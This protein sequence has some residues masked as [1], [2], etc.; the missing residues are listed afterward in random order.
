MAMRRPARVGYASPPMSAADTYD[1]SIAESYDAEY[2]VLRDPSGDQAFYA[3]LARASGGPVLELGCGTGRVILPIAREGIPCVGLD[4]SPTMLDVLRAK[5]PPGN[6]ELVQAPMTDFDLGAA[7]FRLIF[8]AFRPLQ[9]LCTVEEQL[10]T[11]ACVRRHL[12]PG[13]RFAFDLFAPNLARTAIEE[14]PEQEDVRAPDGDGEIRRFA[15]VRRDLAT[16]VLT[17]V[18]RHERWVG[19]AKVSEGTSELRMRWFHRYEVEHLL[20]RAGF[21]VEALYG[22]FD[23]RPFDAKGEMIFVTRAAP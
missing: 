11:L 6:L 22:K 21:E 14:E 8:S 3:D 20:A 19:G 9:H 23:R 5:D 1:R 13:G 16:Q 2:A 18:Y 4:L 12:A 7:R 17:V 10:A 15:R